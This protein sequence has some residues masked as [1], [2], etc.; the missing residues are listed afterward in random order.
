MWWIHSQ[1][2]LAARKKKARR[3]YNWVQKNIK[4]VAFEQGM[5]G[6]VPREANLVCNRRFG[7]CKDMS[8]ILTVMLNTAG[9]PAYYTWIGT[10]HLPYRYAETPLP[11]VDNHMISTIKLNDKFIFLDGTD[12]N[13][14]FGMPSEHIQGKEAL[15]AMGEKNI[16]Y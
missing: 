12:N 3:I 14:V 7:D 1:K 16:R 9:V 11:L 8:S 4:Y 10:R 6:F 5:E 13:C 15:L 2:A